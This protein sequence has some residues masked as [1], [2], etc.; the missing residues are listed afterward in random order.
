MEAASKS[1]IGQEWVLELYL[2][3]LMTNAYLSAHNNDQTVC[4]LHSMSLW[5]R[6][7]MVWALGENGM[8]R[9]Q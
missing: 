4:S 7:T 2:S 8:A 1:Y 5:K 3:G 6:A 9:Y